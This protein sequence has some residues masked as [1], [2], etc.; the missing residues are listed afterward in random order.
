MSTTPET[1]KYVS[2]VNL[3]QLW[4]II[5]ELDK[6]IVETLDETL[7][8]QVYPSLLPE[9][10]ADDEGKVLIVQDGAWAA[11]SFPKAEEAKF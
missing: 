8:Q 11:S 5:L 6:A 4:N 1:K 3:Q 10:T 9:V 7:T 2:D